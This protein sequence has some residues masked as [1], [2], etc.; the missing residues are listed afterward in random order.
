MSRLFK[1]IKSGVEIITIKNDV[2]I[3]KTVKVKLLVAG[4]DRSY[5]LYTE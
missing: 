5:Y 1:V 4:K 2:K 3:P